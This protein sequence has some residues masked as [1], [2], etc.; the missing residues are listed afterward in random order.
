MVSV[1]GKI[2]QADEGS[3]WKVAQGTDNKTEKER[4][5]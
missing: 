5:L 1:T 4:L 2:T 3:G